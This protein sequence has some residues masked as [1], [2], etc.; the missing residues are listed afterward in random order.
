MFNEKISNLQHKDNHG[1]L[2]CKDCIMKTAGRFDFINSIL[3]ENNP[4]IEIEIPNADILIPYTMASFEN[5][6]II[7]ESAFSYSNHK[8]D[9]PSIGYMCDI[10][11]DMM[12]N[13][14]S[15]VGTAVITD[16]ETIKK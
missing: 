16:L 3:N 13:R 4:T 6:P 14:L 9:L 7:L 5:A 8:K 1:Y 15:L 12:E 2:I 11:G 10:H